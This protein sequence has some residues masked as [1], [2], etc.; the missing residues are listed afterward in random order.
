[1]NIPDN[2]D[3][4]MFDYL[5][6]NLAGAEK[7]AFENFLIQHPEFEVDADAWTQAVVHGEDVQF[8]NS[9]ALQK[10]RKVAAAWYWGAAASLIILLGIAGYVGFNNQE[11]FTTTDSTTAQN[12]L[13][14]QMDNSTNTTTTSSN[15]NDNSLNHLTAS[16]G[17]LSFFPFDFQSESNH[18]NA[19]TNT[20]QTFLNGNN[21]SQHTTSNQSHDQ[22]GQDADSFIGSHADGQALDQAVSNIDGEGY[23]G[24][25]KENPSGRN[26]S[27][28][29][30]S[31]RNKY[32]FYDK[33]RRFTRNLDRML[34]PPNLTNL[35]DPEMLT[36]ENSTIGFNPAFT[37]GMLTPRVELNYRNQWYGENLNAQEMSMSFDTYSSQMRGGVGLLMKATD[38][39]Y[40]KFTDYN[41]SL[42]YSP[43][44]VLN[45]F[46]VIEP[47]VKLTMGMVNVNHD[48]IEAGSEFE[49][50]RGMVLSAQD[51][52]LSGM[53]QLFYKDY[54]LGLVVN[55][56]WFYAGFSA[57]NLSH[58][59]TN[60]IAE[61]GNLPQL[62]STRVN[63]MIGFDMKSDPR[64]DS[65][66][67]IFSPFVAY[68]KFGHREDLW[69]GA[70][71]KYDWVQIGGAISQQLDFTASIGMKFDKFK[72]AY[73]YDHTTSTLTNTQMGSHN[74]TV[75]FNGSQRKGKSLPH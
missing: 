30:E 55:T 6:G 32:S 16:V 57:D 39:G 2:F 48:K 35:R 50:D 51:G 5:E 34:A 14:N 12:D 67:M 69:A 28:N 42:T 62:A 41:V 52:T 23:A 25:Y 1:M 70:N 72:L 53:E 54:G 65:K 63:G 21:S 13:S 60:V 73:K 3:R 10:D 71:F 31:K 29:I 38:F 18:S 19:V 26:L 9:N 4:W 27:F 58:H 24:S 45:K 64:A 8:P 74:L 49:M 15:G 46:V 43:K 20:Q 59:F 17:Q 40:G 7:E 56:K 61:Q 68:Q 66:Q 22:E 36:P 47:A 33:L 37:G 75:R 11:D 44:L